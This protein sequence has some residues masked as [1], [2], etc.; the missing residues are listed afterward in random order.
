MTSL[1]L[2][3]PRFQP[4]LL[5][6]RYAPGPFFDEMFD[7]D[8]GPR[9]HYAALVERL[10]EL[11]A[12]EFEERRRTVDASFRDAGIGFTVYGSEEELERIFPFDLIPR[13]IPA[14]EWALVER[15]LAQRVA[16]LEHFLHDVYHEQR[17]LLERGSPPSSCSARGTSAAR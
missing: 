13:V 10:A 5:G 14:D 4:T 11:S 7:A 3:I 17:I 1:P 6:E 12:D 8:G 15:G 16:A 2:P 9:P